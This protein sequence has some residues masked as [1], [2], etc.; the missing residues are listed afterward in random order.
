VNEPR[1]PLHQA[2]LQGFADIRVEIEQR[3]VDMQTQMRADMERGLTGLRGEMQQLAEAHAMLDQRVEQYRRD[4]EA[5]HQEI[6]TLC[7][8]PIR[9]STDG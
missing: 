6:L 8:A 3:F 4:N 5:A 1:H 7:A 9:S 2:M